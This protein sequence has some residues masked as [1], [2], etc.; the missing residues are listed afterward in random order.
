MAGA[1][2]HLVGRCIDLESLEQSIE[3]WSPFT[4]ETLQSQYLQKI[5]S[6]KGN[7]EVLLSAVNMCYTS[8]VH[9]FGLKYYYG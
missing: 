6:V 1:K 7:N 8:G 5:I 3:S 4:G 2:L 9:C